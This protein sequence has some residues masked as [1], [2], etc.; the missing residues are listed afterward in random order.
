MSTHAR[1]AIGLINIWPVVTNFYSDLVEDSPAAWADLVLLLVVPVMI[2]C[3][4]IWYPASPEF[5]SVSISA[6]TVLFGFTFNAVVLLAGRDD[7]DKHA[8][9]REAIG[10]TKGNAVYSLVVG[11]L[12]LV[13]AFLVFLIGKGEGYSDLE[14]A[15][16]FEFSEVFGKPET[17]N[18]V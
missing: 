5:V 9:V 17:G 4:A 2:G 12:S 6:L 15:V 10:M 18:V 11:F 7:S 8:R 3:T 16:V 1:N 14:F 13:T